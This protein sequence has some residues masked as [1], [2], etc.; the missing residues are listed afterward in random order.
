MDRK[1][2]AE[3]RDERLTVRL[4]HTE[5]EEW[6]AAARRRGEEVSRYFRRMARI[7]KK[8]DEANVLSEATGA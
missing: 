3:S 5:R 6:E 4:T 2:L 7:G 1:P 8:V